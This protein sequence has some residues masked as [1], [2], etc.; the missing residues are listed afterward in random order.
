MRTML[1]QRYFGV[2][3]WFFFLPR[4]LGSELYFE[5]ELTSDHEFFPQFVIMVGH[6]GIVPDFHEGKC[7]FYQ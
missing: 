2:F 4:A 1:L 5:A 6:G 7:W 3:F